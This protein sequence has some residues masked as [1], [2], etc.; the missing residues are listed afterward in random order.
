[1]Y[2]VQF[3]GFGI[4]I[5]VKPTAFTVAGHPF[6]WYGII[7][8]VAFLTA[9]AYVLKSCKSFHM[10]EDKFTDAVLVGIIG[11]IVGARIYYVLFDASSQY[12]K[13]P[14]SILYIWQGGLAIYG[15][16]IG[17]LLCGAL[18]AKHRG[19]SVPA[20]LDLASLG[21]LIGQTIG[22][23]GNFVN[24]EAFGTA[25]SLPWRMVSENTEAVSSNGVHP[26][27]L[28]ESLWCLIGFILLHFF[29]R[30][31]R[32]Y[33]GQV[34]LLYSLWYGVGR[35]FIEGLRTDSLLTPYFPLRV[36][37][38]VAAAAVV[39]AV[40]LLIVFRKKTSLSGCGSAKIMELNSIVDVVAEEKASR[41]AKEEAA[42][43]DGNSTIF[44]SGEDAQ[45]V[46]AGESIREPVQAANVSGAEPSDEEPAQPDDAAQDA[47]AASAEAETDAS[48]QTDADSATDAAPENSAGEAAPGTDDK[49]EN[50]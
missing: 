50:S 43:N 29:S 27:F 24:Q 1:M 25:T 35:F 26:C 30:K 33:D 8:A 46:M 38:L 45:K 39:A 10:D 15:G 49:T 17:G 41:K 37:Q 42:I 40:V 9:F 11:G 34:F 16:I 48:A 23:W 32:R 44:E 7:I 36:S 4:S 47:D 19:I 20:V 22:R 14:I 13:N 12:L 5:P 28:Y 2:Q 21:F 6:A 31:L 18:M 3:P